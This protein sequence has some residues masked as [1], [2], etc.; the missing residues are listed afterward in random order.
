M[1]DGM[2]HINGIESVR[3][4]LKRGL[5]DTYFNVNLP[6]YAD[7]FFFRLNEGDYQI[8]TVNRMEPLQLM[9]FEGSISPISNLHNE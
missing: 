9:V 4:L 2:P 6:R 7:G 1:Y 3:T 8:D 5:A